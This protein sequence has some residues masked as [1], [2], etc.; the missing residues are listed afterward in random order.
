MPRSFSYY[1]Q[2]QS[3]S[4]C[5]SHFF[6]ASFFPFLKD[7]WTAR[8]RDFGGSH[9]VSSVTSKADPDRPWR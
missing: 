1:Q 8:R 4:F 5:I 2:S 3:F 7:C 6:K 9:D